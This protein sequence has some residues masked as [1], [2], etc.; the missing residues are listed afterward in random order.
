MIHLAVI[1]SRTWTDE[2]LI[3]AHLDGMRQAYSD[4][5]VGIVSGGADGADKIGARL[6]REMGLEVTIMLPNYRQFGRSAPLQ[7]NKKIVDKADMVLAF[8]NGASRGTAHALGYAKERKKRTLVVY[9]DGK[10]EVR[11]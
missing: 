11:G 2:N 10:H 5:E 4:S 9:P 7:R 8:W 6:A 3:R 1:G